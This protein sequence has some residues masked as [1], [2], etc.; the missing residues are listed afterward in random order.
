MWSVLVVP[1]IVLTL[2][3]G[4]ALVESRWVDTPAVVRSGRPAEP[5][6]G[7]AP[8]LGGA[9]PAVPTEP[10]PGFARAAAPRTPVPPR[11]RPA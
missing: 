9:A 5:T 10:A 4:L 1:V 3:L 2:P 7:R 8:T 6:A 11:V